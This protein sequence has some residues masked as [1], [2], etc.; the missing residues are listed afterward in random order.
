MWAALDCPGAWSVEREAKDQ[1]VVLGRMAARVFREV[2]VQGRYI[3]AGWPVGADGRKLYSGTA[4]FDEEG[5][6]MATAR[7]VGIV[8]A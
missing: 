8:L 3:A 5:G 7:Q 2:S 6:L 1:P 4:L